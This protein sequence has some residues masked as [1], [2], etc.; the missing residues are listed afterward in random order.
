MFQGKILYAP[1]TTAYNSLIQTMNATFANLDEIGNLIAVMANLTDQ[2]ILNINESRNA[3]QLLLNLT[4]LNNTLDINEL[5]IDL[6]FSSQL[7]KF[8]RNF[9]NCFEL[10]RFIGYAT[11]EEALAVGTNLISKNALWAALIF[12]NPSEG[13]SLP[14]IVNYKIRMSSQF[15]HDTN[16][17]QSSVYIFGPEI[18][19]SN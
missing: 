11:E 12:Q 10:N 9:M 19:F 14:K 2:F 5:L 7:L 13:D 16:F 17:A 4:Q 8:I 1:N 3:Y 15:T 18:C 6:E